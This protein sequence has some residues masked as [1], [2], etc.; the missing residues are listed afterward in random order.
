ML[1]FDKFVAL[2]NK[3]NISPSA[4]AEAMGYQR[5]VASR[6]GKGSEPRKAT[7]QRV[8]EF[9]G[10]PLSYFEGVDDEQ[11]E[12]PTAAKGSE[13]LE[14]AGYYKL[15]KENK[16]LIDQMIAQLIKSQSGD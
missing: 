2:C 9:F 14:G 4:A 12:N 13:V 1:F 3:R 8:A 16:K 7:K 5:S 10:V 6:W 15:N 11:K